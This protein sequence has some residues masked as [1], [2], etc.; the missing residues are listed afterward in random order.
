MTMLA[1]YLLFDGTCQKAMEFYQSCLGGDLA[2]TRVKDSPAKDFM[3][4]VQHGKT[5]N[6]HLKSG[7]L[8]VFASDW[9]ALNQ[10]PVQGNTICLFLRGEKFADLKAAFDKLADGGEVTDPPKQ[11]FFGIYAALNDRFGVRW[12]FQA[13]G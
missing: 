6:A 4:A 13:N 8:E 11:M 7:A 10:T 1:P 3:P 2:L 5:L 12:M 9:L